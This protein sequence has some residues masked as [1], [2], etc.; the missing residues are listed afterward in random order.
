MTESVYPGSID[1]WSDIVDEEDEV[2]AS[3]GNKV[4]SALKNMEIALGPGIEGGH[5][6]LADWLTALENIVS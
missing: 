1:T 2:Q 3:W 4:Q 6:S 5:A